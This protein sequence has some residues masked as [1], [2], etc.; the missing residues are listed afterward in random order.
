MHRMRKIKLF[1]A[2]AQAL[3]QARRDF[4]VMVSRRN[5]R[6][7]DEG[8]FIDLVIWEDFLD[9]LAPGGLQARYNAEIRGCDIFVMLFADKVGMHTQAEFDAAVGQFSATGR[10]FVYTYFLPNDASA[11]PSA[12]DSDSLTAFQAR[13]TALRHY[14]TKAENHDAL[15][16]HFEHQLEALKT[17]QFQQIAAA[18][19]GLALTASDGSVVN[20]GQARDI[21][22]GTQVNTGGG[23]YIAGNVRVGG[24]FAGRDYKP[25]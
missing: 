7:I 13:L 23:A 22:T 25:H 9:A 5:Q 8:L 15:L 18:P 14:Q 6:W 20:T 21:V 1:L 16:R 19:P 17:A 3:D 2:S 10:P 12:R 4:E 24:N 11:S